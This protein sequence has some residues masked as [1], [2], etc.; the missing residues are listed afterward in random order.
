MY[1]PE[2]RIHISKIKSPALLPGL[3]DAHQ[4]LEY[5]II[6]IKLWQ[7]D[8]NE[9]DAVGSAIHAQHQPCCRVCHVA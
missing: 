1:L 3:F 2:H 8:A 9:G 6:N 4:N 5:K 7:V